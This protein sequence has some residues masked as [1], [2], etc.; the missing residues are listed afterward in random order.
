[1][2]YNMGHRGFMEINLWSEVVGRSVGRAIRWNPEEILGVTTGGWSRLF[3]Y[4][5]FSVVSMVHSLGRPCL[6]FAQVGVPYQVTI[7]V[8]DKKLPNLLKAVS[9]T[10]ALRK[11]PPASVSLLRRRAEGDVPKLLKALRSQGFY[12]AE[13]KVEIDTTAEPTHIV[14]RI[15][16]GPPYNLTSLDI[17]IPE[18][19]ES[20]LPTLPGANELGLALGEPARSAAILDAE[21]AI[22]AWF[23]SHGFPFIRVAKREVVVDHKAQAVL[24]SFQMEPGPLASF[25][26]TEIEGLESVKETVVRNKIPWTRGDRFDAS[27]LLALRQRLRK[28]GLFASVRVAVGESL[29]EGVYLPVTV[30]VKERKHRTIRAGVNYYTTEGAGG[31]VSW[32]H[33]NLLGR[34][35]RLSLTGT[36][37]QV[38]VAGEGRFRKPEII[39]VDQSLLLNARGGVDDTD[40]YTSRYYGGSLEIERELS[41]RMILGVGPAFR[42]SKVEQLDQEERFRLVSLPSRFNWD[43]SDNLLDPTGG[44]RLALRF[45]PFYDML[46]RDLG[47]VKGY[48]S[49]SRY[50]QLLK[51]PFLVVAGRG[52]LGTIAGAEPEEIPADERFYAGGGDSVRGF[53]FQSVGPRVASTPVGGRS[54]V[55]FSLELRLKVTEKMGLVAF[56]DAGSA[57]ESVLPDFDE[58]LGY[59]TGLGLRYFSPIGPLRIDVAVPLNLRDEIDDRFQIYLSLGQ[60]F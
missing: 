29:E 11:E 48:G 4:I 41:D 31:K 30:T 14:F 9:D 38:T 57:F 49:Y 53:P 1:M 19:E 60:A 36:I 18:A 20:L 6:L 51:K 12:G 34:G 58:E 52:A 10:W 50:Y 24:V 46:S 56:L 22:V 59:G 7:E 8:A 13:V 39:R 16:L 44:G 28:T 2:G 54:L 27:L 21:S 26:S 43:T 37:S 42:V 33:R 5:L 55:E 45:S 40:A 32:E 15:N 25:G 35:E 47:F 17:Q 23:K 3:W